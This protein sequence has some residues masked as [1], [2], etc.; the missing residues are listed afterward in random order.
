MG[1]W[2]LHESVFGIA[3]FI[4]GC[5]LVLYGDFNDRVIGILYIL[6]GVFLVGRDYLDVMHFKIIEHH[7][8]NQD[9]IEE[10]KENES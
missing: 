4:V 6:P 3:W 7:H 5:L 9:E 8:A 10:K 2:R 1:N